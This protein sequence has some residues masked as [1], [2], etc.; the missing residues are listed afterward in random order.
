MRGKA[1]AGLVTLAV[2]AVLAVAGD[3]VGFV[4]LFDGKALDKWVSVATDRF[5][6]RNGVITYDGGPGWLRSSRTYKDFELHLQYRVAR[7]GSHSGVFFRASA[8]STSTTP[9]WPVRG[10]QLQ[11]ADGDSHLMLFGHG[12]PVKFDRKTDV[13]KS[14]VKPPGEWQAIALKV[15]GGRAEVSLNGTLIT[16]CDEI[17]LPQGHIGLQGESGQLEWRALSIKELPPH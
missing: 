14:V 6:V 13:L 5:V 4:S 12:T 2:T 1:G 11:V 8:E 7:P 10:F 9:N 15:V 16:V 3:E 17:A